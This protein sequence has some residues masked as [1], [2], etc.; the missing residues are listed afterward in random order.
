MFYLDKSRELFAGG[1]LSEEDKQAL[2]NCVT[3]IYFAAKNKK[4]AI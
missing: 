2:F 4:G 1:K 3:E